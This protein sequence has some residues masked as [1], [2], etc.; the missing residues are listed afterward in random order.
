[1][2]TNFL[3]SIIFIL[4]SVTGFSQTSYYFP[5]EISFNPSISTPES[6]LGFQ[7]GEWHTDYSQVVHYAQSLAVQSPRIQMEITGYTHEK[8]PLLLLTITSEKNHQNINEIL[9]RHTEKLQSSNYIA[10]ETDPVVVYLAYS[11]HGN[12]PSGTGAALMLMY[13]LAAAEGTKLEELLE[14][15]IIILD[16]CL[17]PDGLHRFAT[18]VNSN[19]SI[20]QVSDNFD[21]EFYEGWPSSRF[22]HFWF[23]LNRDW[24]WVQHPES[25]ARIKTFQKWK[26]NVL[27]DFHEMGTNATYFFQPGI[28]E[29]THPLTPE[30]NQKLTAKIAGFHSKALDKIGS[31]YYS[32]ESFDD[33][34]YG[35]GSTYP[36][37]NGAV[38]ILFEQA[39]SRGH[40]QESVNGVITFPFTIKNQLTTSLSTLEASLAMRKELL[41][42]QY[43][44]YKNRPKNESFIVGT[45]KDIGKLKELI[46]I[47]DHHQIKYNAI[48]EDIPLNGKHFDKT[49]SLFIPGNQENSALLHA[50]FDKRT[51]FKDS[52]FYDVSSWSIDAAF[53]LELEKT[54]DSKWNSNTA[55]ELAVPTNLE[56]S[57]YA[58]AFDWNHYRSPQLAMELLRAGIKIK[59]ARKPFEFQNQKFGYGSIL[60]A[61]SNQ[62]VSSEMLH[63]ILIKLASTTHVPIFSIPTGDTKGVQL[64]SPNF[65]NLNSPSVALLS[66]SGVTAADAGEIWHLFDVKHELPLTKINIDD[67]RT[68]NWNKYTVVIVPNGNYGALSKRNTELLQK[69]VEEG[70]ILI[71]YKNALK[72]FN[73]LFLGNFAFKSNERE[74]K[75]ISFEQRSNF[76]GAQQIGG[77]IFE[78]QIDI[79]HP[80]NYGFSTSKLSVFKN[81]TLIL[82]ADKNSYNNPILYTQKPLI[83]GY[84]SKENLELLKGCSYV[85][86]QS[87]GSGKVIGFTENT[88]FRAFWLETERLLWNAILFAKIM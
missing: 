27:G 71:G 18:W 34:Y 20:T 37:I 58:Y 19:R 63:Q 47:L 76:N 64:G 30:M 23:D 32:G 82:E 74:V 7:I 79:T 49:S 87:K 53:G 36:D 67:S 62:I 77:A 52:L 24:L 51:T 70:G 56:I 38:G 44:F 11:V 84:I 26:P 72:W 54:K 39:S 35:K 28:T 68:V 45:K 1:M 81:S 78:S 61:V 21:R 42:Y 12:E 8:R 9:N 57:S 46:H 4:T 86:I 31:L 15:T 85:K 75:N 83:S 43:N 60:I 59:V 80:I 29:R 55:F 41:E 50:M 13:Y 22:N 33:F 5:K 6:L 17:N 16:P 25:Q 69:W 14:N 48:K 65:V 73:E 66:G 2:N 3:A 10:N 40:A 88:Q